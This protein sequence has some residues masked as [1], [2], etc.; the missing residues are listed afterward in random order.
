MKIVCSKIFKSYST[1][2][3]ENT[4]NEVSFKLESGN[5]MAICGPSGAGKSTLL[6]LLSGLDNPDKG[7]IYYDNTCFSDLSDSEKILFRLQN[8]SVVFQSPNLLKDFNVIEN[9]M[10]PIRYRGVSKKQCREIAMHCLNEVG[11]Q[12]HAD[13]SI[14]TLSGGEA[15]RVGIARAMAKSSK[16]IFADEPTGNLDK[17]NS[18]LV[19][20]N[21]INICESKSITLIIVSHDENIISKTTN[22][23]KMLDGKFI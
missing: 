18:E 22:R 17:I 20:D 9:I 3:N 10:L 13:S 7:E 4:I 23:M 2:K 21:L 12:D 8:I 15:Q 1:L 14:T 16:I 6:N 11:C 19:I 5:S